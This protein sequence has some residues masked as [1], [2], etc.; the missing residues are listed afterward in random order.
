MRLLH[1]LST[2][3]PAT[4]RRFQHGLLRRTV[5]GFV[6]VAYVIPDVYSS[7]S[8]ASCDGWRGR[9]VG[10]AHL[11]TEA[12]VAVSKDTTQVRIPVLPAGFSGMALPGVVAFDGEPGAELW[13]HEMIHQQQMN[14]SGVARFT[15]TY[16]VDW[17]VGRYHGC[18]PRD[19]Y[20][21]VRYETQARRAAGTVT[22][23]MREAY[24]AGGGADLVA[25]WADPPA[26]TPTVKP[27][28]NTLSTSVVYR[29]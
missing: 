24:L 15:A 22:E 13:V 29:S 2:R 17:F 1:A 8:G 20:S 21:A 11:D 7:V 18:G 19:A 3:T 27:A 26:D 4:R 23:A 28:R 5:F 6:L 9:Y 14:D 16:V 25:Y 10:D 12:L